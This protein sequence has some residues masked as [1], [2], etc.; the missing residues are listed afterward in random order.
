[1]R[2]HLLGLLQIPAVGQV[3]GDPRRPEGVA[4]DPGLDPGSLGPPLNH[5]EGVLAVKGTLREDAR[6]PV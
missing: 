1:M 6:L 4:A 5:R 3:D 2:R